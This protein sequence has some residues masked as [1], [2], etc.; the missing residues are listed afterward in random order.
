M[1]V[2]LRDTSSDDCE[3]YWHWVNDPEVRKQSHITR[4]IEWDEHSSWF[5]K[6]LRRDNVRMFVAYDWSSIGAAPLGQIRFEYTNK[7][8]NLSYSV[9]A[10]YRG[11]GISKQMIHLGLQHLNVIKAEVKPDNTISN[12]IFTSLGWAKTGTT[13][14][15]PQ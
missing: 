1:I 10:E 5:K 4:T 14:R 6:Q 15:S 13:Y 7:E 11:Q 8:W 2:A 9:D 3:M 12:H